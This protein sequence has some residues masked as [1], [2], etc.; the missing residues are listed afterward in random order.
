MHQNFQTTQE[1][2]GHCILNNILEMKLLATSV[3]TCL[4]VFNNVQTFSVLHP[5]K[6]PFLGLS[7]SHKKVPGAIHC[8]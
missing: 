1:S 8:C 7:Q 4:V 5:N 3:S 6:C 2:Y